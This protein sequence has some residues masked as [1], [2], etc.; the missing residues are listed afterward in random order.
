MQETLTYVL[1]LLLWGALTGILNLILTRKS[2]IEAWVTA[3]PRVAAWAKFL[4]A[5]GFDPWAAHA[6]LLLL[7]KKKLPEAQ[8]ANSDVAKIEQRKADAKRLGGDG[9]PPS[10]GSLTGPWVDV[11]A[12]TPPSLPG[13]HR[14][15]A[16]GWM[17]LL[18]PSCGIFSTATKTAQDIAHDLCVL[19][20]GKQKL[21]LEE[22]AETYCKDIDPWLDAVVGAEKLGAAK[23]AA[24]APQ[25]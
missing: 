17:L 23:A 8:R 7:V 11:D 14:F 2:Q 25:P 3:N 10:G 22:I 4:R 6:W 12:K 13:V 5:I 9:D 16:I 24:K 19:H 21:S 20:Y 1:P 15:V 18:L